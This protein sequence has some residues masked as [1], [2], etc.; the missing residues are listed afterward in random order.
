MGE[1]HKDQPSVTGLLLNL[2]MK[3]VREIIKKFKLKNHHYTGGPRL[4]TIR[5]ETFQS[6]NGAVKIAVHPIYCVCMTFTVYLSHVTTI[7]V[8]MACPVLDLL[9]FFPFSPVP[10]A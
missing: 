1:G 10:L 3:P 7:A 2:C 4:T 6:Y 5:S 8:T 9:S